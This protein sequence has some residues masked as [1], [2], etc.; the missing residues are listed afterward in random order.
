MSRILAFLSAILLVYWF[1]HFDPEAYLARKQA[2][3]E[4]LPTVDSTAVQEPVGKV[5]RLDPVATLPDRDMAVIRQEVVFPLPQKSL[6]HVISGYGDPRDNGARLHK[7]IDIPAPRGTPVLA[8]AD[9]TITKVANRNNAGK[10]IWLESGTR[11]Y[12]YAHLDSWAVTEGQEV[13]QG[14]EIGT[15]GNTGNARHT[16]PH[17]H[18]EVHIARGKSI[19]PALIFPQP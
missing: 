11:R 8:V 7:G 16:S 12:F 14:E 5:K 2:G 9:G 1:I 10:Q 15:V 3:T 17:L 13:K 4:G 19:D 18:F 6:K